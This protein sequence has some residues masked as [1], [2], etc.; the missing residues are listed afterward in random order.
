[1]R[2]KRESTVI[3]LCGKYISIGF[4]KNPNCGIIIILDVSLGNRPSP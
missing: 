2:M 3:Y 1:M 4:L